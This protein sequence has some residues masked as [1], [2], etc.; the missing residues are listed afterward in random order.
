VSTTGF[1]IVKN[2]IDDTIDLVVETLTQ[3]GD[4][5]NVPF[6]IPD[7]VLYEASII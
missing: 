1:S 6:F 4:E 2:I 7:G 5:F 3:E